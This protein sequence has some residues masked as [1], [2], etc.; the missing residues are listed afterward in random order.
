MHLLALLQDGKKPELIRVG[1]MESAVKTARIAGFY[2]IGSS[3]FVGPQERDANIIEQ[4]MKIRASMVLVSSSF[5]ERRTI[6]SSITVPNNS[7]SFSRG[8]VSNGVGAATYSG[9]TTTYGTKEIPFTTSVDRYEQHAVFMAMPKRKPKFGLYFKPLNQ[10]MRRQIESNSGV[11]VEIVVEDSPAFIGNIIE[12]DILTELNGVP[13]SN[14]ERAGAVMT[15]AK[16]IDGKYEFT[17]FR[18]GERKKIT[19]DAIR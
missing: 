9:M 2:A 3:D 14:V 17:V 19:I 7:T 5:T 10:A 12:G 11:V 1:D 16:P 13:L 4:A 8:T 6:D 15:A 18:N